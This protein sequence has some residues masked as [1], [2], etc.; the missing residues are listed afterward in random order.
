MHDTP[1][2]DFE[3]EPLAYSIPQNGT[4]N[5][6]ELPS[7]SQQPRRRKVSKVQSMINEHP[8]MPQQQISHLPMYPTSYPS[9]VSVANHVRECPVCNA[10]YRC[11]KT[12]YIVGIVLMV[13]LAAFLLKKILEK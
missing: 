5:I 7:F 11:D 10:L 2:T 12:M 6:S 4:T 9:C 13:I 3:E 8:S 1:Y